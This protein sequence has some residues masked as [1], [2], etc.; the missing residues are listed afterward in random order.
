MKRLA[1]SDAAGASA[2]ARR[3]VPK[4]FNNAPSLRMARGRGRVVV[5]MGPPLAADD[6]EED[7][8]EKA[9]GMLLE[10]APAAAVEVQE[11]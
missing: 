6:V 8:D 7:A 3:V 4:S 5:H 11:A 2:P 10:P 9:L 1:E